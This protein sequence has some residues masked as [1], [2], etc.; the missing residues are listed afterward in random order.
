M[1]DCSLTTF[2]TQLKTLLF[3]WYIVYRQPYFLTAGQCIC[4]LRG[5]LRVINSVN[6][7][8]YIIGGLSVWP[9]GVAWMD[10]RSDDD[11]VRR[12]AAGAGR[13]SASVPTARRSSSRLGS[14]L[15]ITT[16]VVQAYK[17]AGQTD[18]RAGMHAGGT[19]RAKISRS[20]ILARIINMSYLY[21]VC[22]ERQKWDPNQTP[23][24]SL[25]WHQLFS[26]L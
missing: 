16:V 10:G 5:I 17:E 2:R 12:P 1:S 8:L 23:H 6:N 4:G 7:N 19:N 15:L 20:A 9:L 14:G 25:Q 26:T 18:R 3:I 24:L 11:D 13:L 21:S 22:Y